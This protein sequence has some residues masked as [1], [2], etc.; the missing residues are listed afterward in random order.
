MRCAISSASYILKNSRFYAIVFTG[1][2]VSLLAAKSEVRRF[3]GKVM[4]GTGRAKHSGNA[5]L[6]SSRLY[7]PNASPLQGLNL[8]Q[9]SPN[10]AKSTFFYEIIPLIR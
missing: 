6:V 5:L 7:L 10:L 9:T 8:S 1:N 4:P 2:S 3:P